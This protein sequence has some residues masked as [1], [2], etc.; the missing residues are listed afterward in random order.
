MRVLIDTNVILDMLLERPAFL[1]AAQAIWRANR[2]VTG[3]FRD[4]Y[5]LSHPERFTISLIG[6]PMTPNSHLD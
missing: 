2:D 6:R 1:G 5:A 3:V 4:M